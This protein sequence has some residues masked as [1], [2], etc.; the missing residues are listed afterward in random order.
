VAPVVELA[1]VAHPPILR[2]GGRLAQDGV[3]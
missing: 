2:A 1:M 3:R